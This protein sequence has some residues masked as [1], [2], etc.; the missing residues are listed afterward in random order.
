M[1][2]HLIVIHPAKRADGLLRLM[3]AVQRPSHAEISEWVALSEAQGI[4][5]LGTVRVL[6]QYD[7][8][9][10]DV[11][12]VLIY[13]RYAPAAVYLQLDDSARWI[14]TLTER[15]S[16]LT[17]TPLDLIGLG[18]EVEA[19]GQLCAYLQRCTDLRSTTPH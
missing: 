13:L 9:S 15:P 16:D 19:A 1:R 4:P 3:T 8:D 7:A 12:I 2:R 10:E 11:F 14:A 18:A 6:P 17:G 5:A